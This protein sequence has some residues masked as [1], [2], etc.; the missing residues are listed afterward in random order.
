MGQHSYIILIYVVVRQPQREHE[1]K[2]TVG[3]AMDATGKNMD[4]RQTV[5]CAFTI[6]IF[7]KNDVYADISWPAH[8]PN[9]LACHFF[10]YGYLK[11]R[12]FQTCS[13]DLQ[14]LKQRISKEINVI[15]PIMSV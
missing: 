7:S 2:L 9:L 1:T 14:N 10:L 12:V 11:K 13:A 6:E 15:S 3:S 4:L 5:H 8:L